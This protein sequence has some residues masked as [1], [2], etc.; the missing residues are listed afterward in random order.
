MNY[1]NYMLKL[2]NSIILLKYISNIKMLIVSCLSTVSMTKTKL[3]NEISFIM[4]CTCFKTKHFMKRPIKKE[5]IAVDKVKIEP[6]TANV[7]PLC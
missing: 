2:I 5:Y 6:K 1:M 4:V 3:P 7:D